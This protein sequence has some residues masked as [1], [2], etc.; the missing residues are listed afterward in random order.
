[1]KVPVV[2]PCFQHFGSRKGD[3][4][5]NTRWSIVLAALCLTLMALGS[6]RAAH[7]ESVRGGGTVSVGRDVVYF[8]V[9]AQRDRGGTSGTFRVRSGGFERVCAVKELQF[10][11]DPGQG[12]VTGFAV[13][14]HSTDPRS[15]GSTVGFFFMDNE[16][17][18]DQ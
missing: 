8:S 6:S 16:A 5:M 17:T 7:A 4:S 1:G 2:A 10:T 14:T 3:A 18:G 9:S 13:V 11:F 15:V 12:R